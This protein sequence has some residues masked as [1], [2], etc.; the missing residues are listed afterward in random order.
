[1]AEDKANAK[2]LLEIIG[3]YKHQN[4]EAWLTESKKKNKA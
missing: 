4:S 3:F 2:L 1:M